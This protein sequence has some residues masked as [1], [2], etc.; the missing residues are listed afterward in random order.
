MRT[1]LRLVAVASAALLLPACTVG[2]DPDSAPSDS[3]MDVQPSI[4][5]GPPDLEAA[6]GNAAAWCALVPPPLIASTLGMELSEPTA[7]FSADEVHC[8][9]LPVAEGGLTI[10][11][12]FRLAQDQSSFTTF[13]TE[14][15][16]PGVDTTELSGV[17]DEAYYSSSEF[18]DVVT[19][20]VTARKGSVVFIV[21]APT[22]LPEVTDLVQQVLAKLV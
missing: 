3:T 11:V 5:D 10:Q 22:P 15:E 21:G 7:S 20:T 14:S 8:T 6:R 4:V 16:L 2:T 17:G 18:G 12:Q 9:Y 19:N 13:R 1:P